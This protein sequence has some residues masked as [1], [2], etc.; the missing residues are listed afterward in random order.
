MFAIRNII[1]GNNGNCSEKRKYML[2]KH[3]LVGCAD[4]D[5]ELVD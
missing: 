3:I 5:N 1:S 4:S 2:M